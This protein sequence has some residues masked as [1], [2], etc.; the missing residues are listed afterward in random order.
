VVSGSCSEAMGF[1]I[2][3]LMYLRED[4]EDSD[5]FSRAFDRPDQRGRRHQ[6]EYTTGKEPRLDIRLV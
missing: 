3:S 1:S 2:N 5:R 6:P 4:A